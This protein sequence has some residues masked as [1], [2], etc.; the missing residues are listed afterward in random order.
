MEAKPDLVHN[1]PKD[2]LGG[3]PSK[4]NDRDESD[5]SRKDDGGSSENPSAESEIHPT[6][7]S[8]ESHNLDKQPLESAECCHLNHEVLLYVFPGGFTK[9]KHIV[10]TETP[11]HF[12]WEYVVL[13]CLLRYI[14]SLYIICN[15]SL[16]FRQVV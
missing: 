16:E 3:S 1:I 13:F 7:E 8:S 4:Q 10:P 9:E 15:Y 6:P 2:G 14:S 12:M 5:K 11:V